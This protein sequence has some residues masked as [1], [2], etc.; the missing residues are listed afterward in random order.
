MMKI[1]IPPEGDAETHAKKI[2]ALHVCKHFDLKS[3]GGVARYIAGFIHALASAE[4]DFSVA[5]PSVNSGFAPENC[6]VFRWRWFQLPV[7]ILR[8]DIVHVHGARTPVAAISAFLALMLHKR[9]IYTPH[10]YYDEGGLKGI[11]KKLWDL[12]VERQML[13][14]CDGVILLSHSWMSYLRARKLSVRHPHI[15][16]N[17]V[18]ES[19]ATRVSPNGKEQYGGTP[20]ILSVSRLDRVKNID[21]AIRALTV[22]GLQNAVLHIVGTGADG[23]RLAAIAE[24]SGVS[25]RIR[26]HGFVE[27]AKVAEFAAA[28]DVFVLPSSQEGMPTTLIEMI[29]R[30]VSVVAS[31]IPGNRAILDLVGLDSYHALHDHRDLARKIQLAAVT[32]IRESIIGETRRHFTWETQRSAILRVYGITVAAE[33]VL[34]GQDGN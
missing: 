23:P 7:L 28:A 19:Y 8:A 2:R 21:T 10:C 25:A 9:V 6:R 26:F 15:I 27:D 14:Y 31:D 13:K 30:G 16:H 33:G 20:V 5:A 12:I 18:S 1:G 4:V 17:C 24:E 11:L 29:L 3:G 22:E 34:S 32:R